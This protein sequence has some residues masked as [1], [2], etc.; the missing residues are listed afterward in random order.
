MIDDIAH[1]RVLSMTVFIRLDNSRVRAILTHSTPTPRPVD[2]KYSSATGNQSH[3]PS[4]SV[5]AGVRIVSSVSRGCWTLYEAGWITA[6]HNEH[7][8]V[9]EVLRW[10]RWWQRACFRASRGRCRHSNIPWVCLARPF[11]FSRPGACQGHL[12]QAWGQN[13]LPVMYELFVYC[14]TGEDMKRNLPR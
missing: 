3:S 1:P 4:R 7:E 5:L 14:S 2:R 10:W 8:R 12:N 13:P 11:C 6:P 9:Q